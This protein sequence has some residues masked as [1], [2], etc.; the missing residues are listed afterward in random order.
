MS[1]ADV[2][3]LVAHF[4]RLGMPIGKRGTRA[5]DE[6]DDDDDDDENGTMVRAAPALRSDA[7]IPPWDDSDAGEESDVSDD[8][9]SD[10]SY[11][12]AEREL[13]A[14]ATEAPWDESDD[15]DDDDDEG[16]VSDVSYDDAER[17]L[18]AN[19]AEAPW[20]ESDDGGEV[21]DDDDESERELRAYAP[22]AAATIA[23]MPASSSHSSAPVVHDKVLVLVRWSQWIIH[24]PWRFRAMV[25]STWS[26]GEVF[27]Y[28][29]REFGE[30]ALDDWSQPEYLDPDVSV[31]VEV[32]WLDASKPE[33]GTL[34]PGDPDIVVTLDALDAVG[35]YV[36]MEFTPPRVAMQ[37]RIYQIPAAQ[38]MDAD[39]RWNGQVRDDDEVEISFTVVCHKLDHECEVPPVPITAPW[40]VFLAKARELYPALGTCIAKVA[41]R[42]IVQYSAGHPHLIDASE[43]IY[44][45]LAGFVSDLDGGVR[46]HFE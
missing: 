18:L 7:S 14:K 16:E 39:E 17:E 30:P 20:D 26:V 24:L 11:D 21:S 43:R 3:E 8:E 44:D 46:V 13:L 34:A 1:D 10:V 31:G 5:W 25:P 6:S 15:D 40:S 32:I 9:V 35:P 28:L 19:A 29:A 23:P 38:P 4:Q 12:D 22:A 37:R 45:T 36:Q 41:G 27:A 42:T 33:S 2:N